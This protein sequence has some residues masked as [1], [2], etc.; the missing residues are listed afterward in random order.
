MDDLEIKF[1]IAVPFSDA[2]IEELTDTT[3]WNKVIRIR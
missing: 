3:D 2:Y 1:S